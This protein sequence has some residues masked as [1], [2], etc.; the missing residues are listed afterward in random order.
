[1]DP[2]MGTKDTS[3]TVNTAESKIKQIW[4]ILDQS[5]AKTHV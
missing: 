4:R 1:M 3:N 2:M 5:R